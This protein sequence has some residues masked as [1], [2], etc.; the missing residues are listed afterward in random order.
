MV[1]ELRYRGQSF[2]LPIA[3]PATARPDELRQAF[4][5]EHEQR[6]GYA[7]ADQELQLVTIRVA[8]ATV[9]AA[10]PAGGPGRGGSG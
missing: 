3:A 5:A 8:A 2:E 1:F 9:G 10:V 4:E 7:D 6:Y